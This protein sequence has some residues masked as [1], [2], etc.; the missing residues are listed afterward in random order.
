M[1]PALSGWTQRESG[2]WDNSKCNFPS[3]RSIWVCV[4]NCYIYALLTSIIM[5]CPKHILYYCFL[6]FSSNYVVQHFL[7][8]KI[9]RFTENILRKFGG[10]YLILSLNK[11]GSN[12]VEKCLVESGE[13]HS[14]T[15]I[16]ELL[17][18]PKCSMLLY[19]PYGNYVFQSAL[20]VA[21]VRPS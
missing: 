2:G 14:A 12:V 5:I 21:K 19:D 6:L 4:L 9:P 16:F 10:N 17:S 20:S 1:C 8:L 11:Y 13:E 18:S 3:R 7:E 15:I